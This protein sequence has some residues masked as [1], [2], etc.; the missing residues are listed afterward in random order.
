MTRTALS[1]SA[2]LLTF[3]TASPAFSH[4]TLE[5]REAAIGGPAKLTFR[6]PHGCGNHATTAVRV[7]IPEGFIAAKPMPKPGWKLKVSSGAYARTH[8]YFHGTK[9]SEGTK[10]IAWSGNLPA[11][12]YDEFV[13]SGFLS[14]DLTPG[15]TLYFPVVQ[16]CKKDRH[17]WIEIP[18]PG[19][20]AH[21][22]KEPAPGLRLTPRT[23]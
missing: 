5:Q 11:A 21:D 23:R 20:N 12:Y 16:D 9:L 18:A 15:A 2:C 14:A 22:L 3:I 1:L 10:E 8:D 17:R 13:I 6:V 19:Q 7:A 4:V